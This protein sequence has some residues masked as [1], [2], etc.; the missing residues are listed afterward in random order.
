[1]KHF[2]RFE[3]T[4]KRLAKLRKPEIEG[5]QLINVCACKETALFPEVGAFRSMCYVLIGLRQG[6]SVSTDVG[7]A[8][9]LLVHISQFYS[10]LQQNSDGVHSLC[11]A[12]CAPAS[13]YVK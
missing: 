7:P 8:V 12:A 10:L 2:V 11:M 3:I 5:F 6:W 9:A 1:M 13:R 4:T